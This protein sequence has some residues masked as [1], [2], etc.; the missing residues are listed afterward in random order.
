MHSILIFWKLG[1]IGRFGGLGRFAV[2]TV[3]TT[4][5]ELFGHWAGTVRTL[6]T[7]CEKGIMY[8]TCTVLYSTL[9]KYHIVCTCTVHTYTCGAK[10]T[11]VCTVASVYITHVQAQVPP[12][13]TCQSFS[14]I[15]GLLGPG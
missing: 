12:K 2:Y 8:S 9:R 10:C 14:F 3:H 6:E 4:K 11:Y 15:L 5:E 1:W 7:V 13:H